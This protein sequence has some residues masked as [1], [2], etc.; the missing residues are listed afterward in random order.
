MEVNN[1][2]A[3]RR[4]PT[5]TDAVLAK[6]YYPML[7]ELAKQK[8]ELTFKEFVDAAKE[9]YPNVEEVQNAIPVST[10]RRFEY[11]RT[12][13][14]QHELPD[15]SAWVVSQSGK[16]GDDFLRDFNPQEEREASS[17]INWDDYEGDWG[18]F[19]EQLVKSTIKVK[20]IKKNEARSIMAKYANE[21]RA[22]IEAHIPNPKKLRYAT[23]V[24]PFAAPIIESLMEGYEV[25]VAFDNV[26]FDMTQS[27]SAGAAE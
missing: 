12:Y 5:P 20:R 25:E 15:L 10:G 24:T 3:G 4:N 17:K 16:F 9:R 26:I 7:C 22:K 18:E 19:V 23:L 13:T 8:K 1:F 11:V 2:L 14:T 27:R 6:C 21:L